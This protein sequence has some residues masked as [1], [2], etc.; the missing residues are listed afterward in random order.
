MSALSL[1]EEQI[2]TYRRD[3]FVLARGMFSTEEAEII[4]RTAELDDALHQAAYFR[5]DATGSKTRMTVWN[6][7][8]DDVFGLFARSERIVDSMEAL[9]GEEVYHYN[10]KL[11]AKE[12]FEGGAWEWHQDYGYW[13]A[14]GCLFPRMSTCMMALDPCVAENGCLEV[15]KGSHLCGRVDHVIS[16]KQ[17]SADPQRVDFLLQRLERLIIEQNPGDVLFFHANMLH[18]SS[19]NKSAKRR[20]ALLSCYNGRTNDPA[21]T[22]H[23]PGYTKLHKVPGTAILEAGIRPTSAD[24]E[25]LAKAHNSLEDAHAP[26]AAG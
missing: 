5:S 25:F 13:Y 17:I 10:S 12:A 7:P 3:G 2:Q 4:R 15:L 11:N 26:A 16:G 24:K 21:I 8:G 9:I 1:S 20:W 23:H 19:A 18:T 14:S 22:H 6:H